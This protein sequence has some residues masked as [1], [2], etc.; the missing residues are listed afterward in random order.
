MRRGWVRG[1]KGRTCMGCGWLLARPDWDCSCS[2]WWCCSS[3]WRCS[4]SWFCCRSC[5]CCC[6]CSRCWAISSWCCR[7]SS[8]GILS[9]IE[10]NESCSQVPQHRL[11]VSSEGN[12]DDTYT[13]HHDVH[14]PV[15]YEH[16][17]ITSRGCE[18]QRRSVGGE[19]VS[20]RS[21][22]SDTLGGAICCA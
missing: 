11:S 15:R 8:T 16:P 20:G 2:R 5:R 21:R 13:Q 17:G 14:L 1:G 7:A 3:N 18:D 6:W 9:T 4:R 10:L 12:R 22:G 19:D